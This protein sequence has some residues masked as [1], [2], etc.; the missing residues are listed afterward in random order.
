VKFP[1]RGWRCGRKMERSNERIRKTT[2]LDRSLILESSAAMIATLSIIADTGSKSSKR[3]QINVNLL[4]DDGFNPVVVVCPSGG[5]FSSTNATVCRS[6]AAGG[7]MGGDGTLSS[8]E[9]GGVLL[10]E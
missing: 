1:T 7:V 2:Y 9:D 5:L 8:T 10:S 3:N 4:L 6:C